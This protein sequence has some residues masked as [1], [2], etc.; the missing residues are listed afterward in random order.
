MGATSILTELMQDPTQLV[1]LFK[2][3]A[4]G[5]HRLS[6]ISLFARFEPEELRRLYEIGTLLTLRPQA[7]VIFEGEPTRGMFVLLLGTV[8]VYKT[9]PVTG[10]LTRLALLNEGTHFGELSLFDQAPRSAT[11][12][13]ESVCHLFQLDAGAFTA[14]LDAARVDLKLR[15]YKTCAEELAARFRVLNGDYINSQQLLWKYALR[16]ADEPPPR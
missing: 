2:D 12:V 8:S 6:E 10:G 7:H 1:A 14:Y 9:D 13:A 16:K 11:V 3:P 5:A 4:W 15:F